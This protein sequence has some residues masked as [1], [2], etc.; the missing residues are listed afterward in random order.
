MTD[1]VRVGWGYGNGVPYDLMG[2]FR[3]IDWASFA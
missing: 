3:V 2:R 1:S